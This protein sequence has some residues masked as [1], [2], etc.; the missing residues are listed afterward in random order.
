MLFLVCLWVPA[1]CVFYLCYAFFIDL[2][3]AHSHSSSALPSSHRSRIQ[4]CN[5]LDS[6]IIVILI[7]GM[8]LIVDSS[9]A[10]CIIAIYTPCSNDAMNSV[11]YDDD[12][13]D[14]KGEF[15]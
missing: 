2:L 6:K 13:D 5:H 10:L 7:T 14:D 11:T 9:P 3:G 15:Y 1:A 12:N 4:H 8:R